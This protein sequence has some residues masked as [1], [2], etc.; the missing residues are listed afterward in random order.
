MRVNHNI[1]ALYSINELGASEAALQKTIRRLSTGLRVNAA[2]D[3]AAGLAIS[4]KMRSQIRGLGQAARNA[5]DDVSMLQTAE[6]ALNE[7]H[8]MLHRMRE[9]AVQ[10]ANDTL[11]S[12]DRAFIQL[13][14]DRLREAIDRAAKTAQFKKSS[15]WAA[16]CPPS[17]RATGSPR[18]RSFAIEVTAAPGAGQVQKSNIFEVS[19]TAF[20]ER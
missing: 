12:Q 5:Q 14:V 16:G 18:R 8:S 13:E 10:G 3:D 17:D 15:C 9:L 11:M 6:G 7:I 19:E 4:E 2:S 1:P 20:E